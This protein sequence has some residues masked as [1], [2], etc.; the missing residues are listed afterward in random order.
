MARQQPT[1][2]LH[3]LTVREIIAAADGDHTDG[4]G[5]LLRISGASAAWVFR[6]TGP[7]GKR[8]EMGLGAAHRGGTAQAGDSVKLA[9]GQAHDARELLAKGL[10][11]IDERAKARDV[12]RANQQEQKTA[13]ARERTTL[14]R[15]ARDYHERVIEPSRTDKHG[16]QWIASLENH[17]PASV[18]HAP[19]DGITAPQ[20]LEALSGVRALDDKAQRIPE[21]LQR[22][23]QRL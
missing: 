5:L 22:V 3:R 11:P 2:S 10:D 8:R 18:W 20:L 12:A 7:A 14:A 4:G 1:S 9:R 23:R 16:A 13:K 6:F 19:I 21:T 17:V 15:W